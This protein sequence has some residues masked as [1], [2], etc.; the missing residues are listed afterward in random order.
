MLIQIALADDHHLVRGGIKLQLEK[1]PEFEVVIEAKNGKDL[2]QQLEKINPLPQIILMDISMPIMN[3]FEATVYI[4]NNF[5]EIKVIAL[6]VSDDM[7]TISKMIESG[8]NAYLLKDSTPVLVKN[9]IL[10]VLKKGFY[11]DQRVI[12][13]MMK[14]KEK[15]I[16]LFHSFDKSIGNEI[17]LLLSDREIEFIRNCC[18]ELTYKQIAELMQVTF[19]TVDGYRDSV[20]T[21][22]DIKSRTGL[23][24]FAVHHGL[25]NP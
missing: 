21:K 19:R 25:V 12:E 23:V 22:L 20:F 11:Y 18:S 9:T 1:F 3:G 15:G 8:A 24:L 10:E 4:S 17:N 2:I 14:G 16:H 13:S 7:A 6:S 5:P